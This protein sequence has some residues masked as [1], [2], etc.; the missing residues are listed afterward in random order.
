[1]LKLDCS[2]GRRSWDVRL[3]GGALG[4]QTSISDNVIERNF[5]DTPRVF[6]MHLLIFE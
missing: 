3:L 1:M 4:A 2:R 5:A 6:I